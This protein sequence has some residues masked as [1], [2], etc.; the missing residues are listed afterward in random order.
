MRV[1]DP[2]SRATHPLINCNITR[3]DKNYSKSDRLSD[4]KSAF[5]I[6]TLLLYRETFLS[7]NLYDHLCYS[8][9]GWS[10][11]V[12]FGLT[13]KNGNRKKYRCSALT[14]K[15]SVREWP[16]IMEN[17]TQNLVHGASSLLGIL[18]IREIDF[19]MPI[20]R[21]IWFY[22][23]KIRIIN[24]FYAKEKNGVLSFCMRKK[25]GQIWADRC[26]LC[27]KNTGQIVF[28]RKNDWYDWKR[29]KNDWRKDGT[30]TFL[31]Q[32]IWGTDIF[33]AK[34]IRGTDF[35]RPKIYGAETFFYRKQYGAET[36]FDPNMF[37]SP[38]YTKYDILEWW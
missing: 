13:E 21:G 20:I 6:S 30:P 16:K 10:V 35:F 11:W 2:S 1:R 8:L 23:I 3:L 38:P 14:G 19:F 15:L 34:K 22:A 4:W 17:G 7:R 29:L 26:F 36:F 18:K 12:Q 5:D 25:Y 37:W 32:K 31:N 24:F 9:I 27:E 33:R 28:M